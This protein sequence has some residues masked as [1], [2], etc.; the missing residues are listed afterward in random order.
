MARFLRASAGSVPNREDFG[1][2]VA[3]S[4]TY[5]SIG[6]LNGL[7]QGALPSTASSIQTMAYNPASQIVNL[8]QQTGAY[9]WTGHP[10]TTTNW[11]ANGL[12]QDAALAA[13]P[14]DYDTNGNLANDNTHKF[15]YDYQRRLT[16]VKT[17][18]G[19]QLL[20]ITYDP[21]D[22]IRQTT[23]GSTV[24]QFLYDGDRLVA[25]YN[26]GSTT[27]LHRYV[28]GAGVDEPLVWY[29]GGDTST[30]RWLHADRQGSII[31]WS[32][33]NG[34]A[35]TYT[36]GPYGEPQD[37]SGSRFRYTGQIAL[38]EAQIYHYKA[39]GYDPVRGWF[40]QTDP[41]GQG[42][43]PNLYE[44]V[45]DDPTNQ[46]D[47]TGN[48]PECL[49]GAAV[50]IGFE[51]YTGELQKS[52]S[53][54][55][56]G[57][58]GGLAVSAA[59]IGVS[60]VSGGV[61]T[62]AAAKGAALAVR[63]AEAAGLGAKAAQ[64]AKVAGVAASQALNGAATKTATNAVEGKPLGTGVAAAAAVS[65]TVGTAGRY[66]GNAATQAVGG[67]LG[68]NAGTAAR[69]VSKVI[70]GEVKKEATCSAN[71]GQAC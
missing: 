58:Y 27:P 25:E 59:K 62:I 41:I 30:R 67:S 49:I 51:L 60:A 65:G 33:V 10:T 2:I 7:T 13:V 56:H 35:T 40:L 38:P 69:I 3:V 26:G 34:A 5:D 57:N 61:S 28:H 22:R 6:R 48:C 18:A 39:R 16:N 66:A 43:D 11:V 17:T 45:K 37:W 23:A 36:Y 70:T 20:A 64:V 32:D 63:A 8:A 52:V 4:Y 9:V 47:P 31:A 29:V 54:A 55:Q 53:D 42:P 50:E 44:Y 24:T 21:F 68:A 46:T 19:A 15:T 12:N 71:K 1:K 14:G